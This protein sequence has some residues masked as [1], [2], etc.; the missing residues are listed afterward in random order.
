MNDDQVKLIALSNILGGLLASGHY[1]DKSAVQFDDTWDYLKRHRYGE[2]GV[3]IIAIQ[4]AEFLLMHS[5]EVI[6]ENSTNRK[7]N[8]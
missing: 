8:K 2:E 1:T 6:A 7:E 3:R 5:E 4:D